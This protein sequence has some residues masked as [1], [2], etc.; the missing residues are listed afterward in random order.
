[1]LIAYLKTVVLL[2]KI[3]NDKNSYCFKCAY[4]MK[5]KLYEDNYNVLILLFPTIFSDFSQ[6]EISLDP[7]KKSRKIFRNAGKI[8]EFHDNKKWEPCHYLLSF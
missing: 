2:L 6:C 1:M 7:T 5:L 3:T 4:H 8:G